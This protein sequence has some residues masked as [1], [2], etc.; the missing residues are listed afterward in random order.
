MTTMK[1]ATHKQ[2]DRRKRKMEWWNR[3][4]KKR[5]ARTG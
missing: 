3:D 2:K 4:T 1:S 5:N